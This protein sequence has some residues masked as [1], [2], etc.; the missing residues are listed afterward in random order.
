MRTAVIGF[1]TVLSCAAAAQSPASPTGPAAIELAPRPSPTYDPLL[2]L[3]K[4]PEKKI[5]LI[6]GT[7]TRL[8]RVTDRLTVQPFGAKQKMEVAFDTRTRFINNGQPVDARALQPG[9]RIYLDTMLNGTKIFAKTVWIGNSNSTGSGRGQVISFDPGRGTLLVRDE[10][11][12][13]PVKFQTGS[14]TV[15]RRGDQVLPMTQLRPGT[16]IALTFGPTQSG[17]GGVSTIS[18]LAE[19]GS[20]FS[21]FGRITY[22]D[23][24]RHMLAIANEPD[25]KTYEIQ[26]ESLPPSSLRGVH[27]GSQVGISAVFNGDNYIARSIEAVHGIEPAR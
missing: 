24:S 10:I 8:D 16:L 3:P 21:F 20:A 9:Q 26:L 13:E 4:L 6:G 7:V 17:M 27:P 19:P 15:V 23:L 11:S 12:S 2:D 1:F 18:I 22:L 14:A 5:T 25:N